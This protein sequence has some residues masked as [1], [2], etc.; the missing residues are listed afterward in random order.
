MEHAK[1]EREIYRTARCK[2]RR[3]RAQTRQE[4]ETMRL[5]GFHFGRFNEFPVN[6]TYWK[7]IV[8]A[9]TRIY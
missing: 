1:N 3:Y 8:P 9:E 4:K 6:F 7:N 5:N 2:V